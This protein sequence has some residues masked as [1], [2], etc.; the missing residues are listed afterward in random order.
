MLAAPADQYGQAFSIARVQADGANGGFAV[1]LSGDSVIAGGL[2][3]PAG[4]YTFI[5]RTFAPAGDQDGL[6]VEINGARTRRTVPIGQWA[7][8]ALPFTLDKPGQVTLTVIGQE[9]GLLVDEIA[10]VKGTHADGAVDTTKLVAAAGGGQVGLADLQRLQT[11]CRLATFP[12]APGRVL[13]G[14]D[15]EKLPPGVS[16]EHALAPGHAGQGLV[17]KMP[18]GRFDMAL[19]GPAAAAMPAGTVEWWVRPRPAAQVWLDQGWHYFLHAAPAAGPRLDL[20]RSPSTQL[21]LSLSAGDRRE[22]LQINTG[23]LDLQ[24]WHHL[25]VSWD[26]R[27][28]RQYLWLLVDG[29]GFRSFFPKAFEAPRFTSLQFGNMPSSDNIPLLPMDGGL[30]EIRVSP[31][32]VSARLAGEVAK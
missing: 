30:D 32:P 9:P 1:A 31:E 27:G 15:F 8:V 11:A 6:F 25:L 7:T 20:S 19:S 28:D 2:Q 10:V 14:E 23:N 5:L 17:L 26:L 4:S 22:S 16:G 18:D 29:K 21:Q 13:C 12:P 24:E 3:L